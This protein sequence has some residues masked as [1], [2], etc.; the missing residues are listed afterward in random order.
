MLLSVFQCIR[1]HISFWTIHVYTVRTFLNSADR[2]NSILTVVTLLTRPRW[3]KYCFKLFI[4]A[5]RNILITSVWA[6]R[7]HWV[8]VRNIYF[9]VLEMDISTHGIR[10][11]I[12]FLCSFCHSGEVELLWI[13]LHDIIHYI[14]LIQLCY[15]HIPA[16][17]SACMN[18][19]D[20]RGF[21]SMGYEN[22]AF[23]FPKKG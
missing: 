12:V 21:E 13:F 5:T 16:S 11:Y 7:T 22:Q 8:R 1:S 2:G 18:I 15:V 6:S 3:R 20:L 9:T 23:H 17:E 4:S 14:L 10:T 19:K